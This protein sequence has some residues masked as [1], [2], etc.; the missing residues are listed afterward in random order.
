[1]DSGMNNTLNSDYMTFIT[2]A[3]R[4]FSDEPLKFGEIKKNTQKQNLPRKDFTINKLQK[5]PQNS[6][7]C[8]QNPVC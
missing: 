4:H 1:M 8:R 2:R 5:V 6:H 7:I 3:S